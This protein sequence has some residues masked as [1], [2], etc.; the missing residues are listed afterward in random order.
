MVDLLAATQAMFYAQM[1]F[2]KQPYH[3][4]VLTG[5]M[6]VTELLGGNPRHQRPTRNGEACFLEVCQEALHHDQC[7]SLLACGLGRTGC[8]IPVHHGD[9]PIQQE[10]W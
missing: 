10:S 6:W 2:F 9:K 3:N 1:V 7:Q 4:S 8:N 5:Q